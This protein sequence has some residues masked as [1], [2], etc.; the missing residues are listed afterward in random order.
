MHGV[1]SIRCGTQIQSA[2]LKPGLS[3]YVLLFVLFWL[4]V[5]L[6][7]C[8]EREIQTEPS[9][10]LA[11]GQTTLLPEPNTQGRVSLEEALKNRRSIRSFSDQSV[12]LDA[13]SQLLWAAQGIT[14]SRG[15]RTAPSAGALYPLEI[16]LVT[17]QG[18][19]HYHPGSNSLQMMKTGDHRSDLHQ[20]ALRQDAVLDAPVVLV[21]TAVYGRTEEKYGPERSPRYVHLEA[22]HAAQNVLLQAVALDLGAVPIGAFDDLK[23]QGILALPSDHQPLYLIPIGYPE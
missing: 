18:V 1:P 23:V 14:D 3:V 8:V 22:G 4:S 5:L 16:Y 13:I 17:P 2:V 20:A 21:V 10:K 15:H 9:S 11:T 12:D 6:S 19:A 7:G